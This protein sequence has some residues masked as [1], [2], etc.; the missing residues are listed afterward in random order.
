MKRYAF[1]AV[2]AF[3]V[4]AC[5]SAWMGSLNQD[6]GWYLYAANLVAEGKMPYRDFFYTQGPLMPLAYAPFASVWKNWGILGARIFTC[7]AGLAGILLFSLLAAALAPSA[8]RR[9]AGLAAFFLLGCNIYH[10]YYLTIPKTYATAALFAGAGALAFAFACRAASARRAG[11]LFAL[12]GFAFALAAGARISTGAILATAGFALLGAYRSR[13]L[14]FLWFGLGGAAGLA[15]VYGPFVADPGAFAGLYEA[16]AY[17]AARGGRSFLFTAGSASRLVRW[18]LPS[19]AAFA[20]AFFAPRRAAASPASGEASRKFALWTLLASFAAVAAVQI[21]APFPYEDYQVPVM[22]IFSACAAAMFAGAFDD[23]RLRRIPLAA[24]AGLS[25]AVSFGSPMLE[26]W[27]VNGQDRFWPLKKEATELA[28]LREAARMVEELD[29]G[30]RELLTQDLY[31]AIET[32]RK[33]PAGLEMGPFSML[34]FDGWTNLLESA[35][36]PVAALS[37]YTFAILPPKCEERPFDEQLYFWRILG[38]NYSRVGSIEDFGQ[39][40]TKLLFLKRKSATG[41]KAEESVE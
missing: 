28:Q 20:L 17:H 10:V 9:E 1:A 8:R 6:E 15:A 23:E 3:A 36:S 40:A 14:A 38:K 37:G 29:P 12:S 31:L 26:K 5:A 7:V 35:R 16:Q 19:F 4:L 32:D 2:L 24:A 34:D 27:T 33:V 21:A 18:Y 41:R 30:G 11:A 22:G 39:N 13:G 25:L